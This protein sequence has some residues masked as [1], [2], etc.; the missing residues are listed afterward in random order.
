MLK[1]VGASWTQI[2]ISTYIIGA[3]VVLGIIAIILGETGN[4]PEDGNYSAT[5]YWNEETGF[6]IEFWGQGIK[7][8]EIP[9]GAARAYYQPHL[10]TTGWAILDIETQ[11]NYPDW[12]QA[13]AAGA[14]EGSLTWQMIYWHWQNTVQSPCVDREDYCNRVKDYLQQNFDWVKQEADAKSADPYWHQIKLFYMQLEGIKFGFELGV[15]RSRLDMDEIDIIDFVWMNSVAD[16]A[17]LD[18]KLNATETYKK[19]FKDASS[20][21]AIKNSV[22]VNKIR[23]ARSISSHL[24]PKFEGKQNVPKVHKKRFDCGYVGLTLASAF[25]KLVADEGRLYVAHNSAGSYASMLKMLKHYEFAYHS[26]L[27]NIV[28]TVPNRK[29]SFSSYPATIHSGDDFYIISNSKGEQKYVVTGVPITV[30]DETLWQYSSPVEQIL[31][32][33]RMQAANRL[34]TDGAN[35][36]ELLMEFNSGT[37]NKEWT[38]VD[39]GK[40]EHI[41]RF[42]LTDPER[43]EKELRNITNLLWVIEQIPGGFAME[44]QTE[45]LKSRSYWASYGLPYYENISEATGLKK[46]YLQYGDAFSYEKTALAEIF[47]RDQENATNIDTIKKLM[48]SNSYKKDPFSYN[49]PRCAIGGRGDVHSETID[50][51]PSGV[52]DAKV[53][54][55]KMIILPEEPHPVSN[56]TFKINLKNLDKVKQYSQTVERRFEII[57]GPAYSVPYDLG[58]SDDDDDDLEP[59]SWGRSE[60][61]DIPHA[62]H[63]DSWDFEA[64]TLF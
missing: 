36:A 57:A 25:V 52:T 42:L 24:N 35:W 3:V 40:F 26:T 9:K 19:S 16:L 18:Y 49:N 46:M 64:I 20:E 47:R 56:N 33:P 12:V 1:V 32:G 37:A 44:D 14:L 23:Q 61:S 11:H 62:G 30:F 48:R 6:R 63:P 54:S 10:N 38:I 31:I 45:A 39:F 51:E 2:R 7:Q 13:F 34:A 21:N 28:Q 50:P 4:I 60:F 53:F 29:L 41:A 27:N 15:S 17:D 59:F 5:A 43:Y 55:S 58:N 22:L 8:E